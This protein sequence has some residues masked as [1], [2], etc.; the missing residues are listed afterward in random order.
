MEVTH[1]WTEDVKDNLLEAVVGSVMF[2]ED[3]QAVISKAL[4]RLP[5][6]SLVV[7]PAEEWDRINTQDVPIA[8]RSDVA[9]AFLMSDLV[10]GPGQ[11][12]DSMGIAEQFGETFKHGE[13][14]GPA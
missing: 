4:N 11:W 10:Y 2:D 13:T 8:E 14:D 12:S 7:M 3:E 1:I 6:D 9:L 5:L